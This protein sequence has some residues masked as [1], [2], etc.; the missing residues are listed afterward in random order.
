MQAALAEQAAA[1]E[2]AAAE[3]L[4]GLAAAVEQAGFD[5]QRAA[6]HAVRSISRDTTLCTNDD[7]DIVS[8]TI[9]SAVRAGRRGAG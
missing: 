8:V 2:S 6:L 1:L 4:R 5:A 3:A 9:V 7:D